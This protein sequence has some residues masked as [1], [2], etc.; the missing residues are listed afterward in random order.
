MV[1]LMA[2]L[3]MV[4]PFVGEGA[5][6]VMAGKAPFSE[7]LAG[8]ALRFVGAFSR[9]FLAAWGCWRCGRREMREEVVR[10]RATMGLVQRRERV[11]A[12]GGAAA[13]KRSRA[14]GHA[15]GGGADQRA[16]SGIREGGWDALEGCS[17]INVPGGSFG[18][19]KK[20]SQ[21][22][23]SL[24]DNP[25]TQYGENRCGGKVAHTRLRAINA[26]DGTRTRWSNHA[27]DRGSRSPCPSTYRQPGCWAVGFVSVSIL[28]I[29]IGRLIGFFAIHGGFFGESR[30]GVIHRDQE[31]ILVLRCN[32]THVDP[33]HD[34]VDDASI[35]RRTPRAHVDL[36]HRYRVLVA[37]RGHL[38][39][40]PRPR[41]Q[42]EVEPASILALLDRKSVV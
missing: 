35:N 2:G 40:L 33:Q 1:L 39:D 22:F 16:A 6:N 15:G 24:A 5:W 10:Q 13:G 26:K 4:V 42:L 36:H 11:G 8:D 9:S 41:T 28:W 12:L 25:S 31:C 7:K 19:G 17:Q 38:F 18:K 20:E 30:N 34:V 14:L 27:P 37:D 32:G 21:A 29:Q 3:L 23:A